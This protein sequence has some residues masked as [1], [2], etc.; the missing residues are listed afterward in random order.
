MNLW[1]DDIRD[2]EHYGK[3]DW[4]WA[5][6]A[7][8]AILA[9]RRGD[10]EEAS[11]DHDL[12]MEQMVVGGFNARIHDDGV[13]SGYDVLLWLEQN[14]QYWPPKGI[15]V[16]SQNSA[17]RQRMEQAIRAHYGRTFDL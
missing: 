7:F 12:T 11:F 17:G 10:I 9:L 8:E 2:P 4:L 1:M 5:H 6:T 3:A 16:H 13:K 14:P 15:A